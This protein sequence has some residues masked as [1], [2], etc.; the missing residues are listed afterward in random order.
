MLLRLADKDIVI[1]E[2]FSITVKAQVNVY[3]LYNAFVLIDRNVAKTRRQRYRL[4][5][6]KF[7]ITVKAQFNIYN[8]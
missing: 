3:N 6:E 5:N 1:T 2:E 7:S 8:L 4:D